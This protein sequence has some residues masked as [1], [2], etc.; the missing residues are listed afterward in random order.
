MRL[1]ILTQKV[2]INDDILGFFHR[3]IEEF[4]K[5]CELVIVICLQKGECD[6]PNNVKALSLGK[7]A[8]RSRL[9]Y[10]WRF[11][12]YI[13]E[14]RKNYNNVFVHMNQEYV[15]LGGLFWK[16]FGK[17]I[18]MWRN[19]PYGNFLTYMAVFLSNKVFCTSKYSYTAKFKKT[20]IMPVGI[21]TN[22]FKRDET[23]PRGNRS[24]LFLG[25]IAPVKNVAIFV[26]ALKKLR[27]EGVEFS[28]TIAG[29]A[30]D[31]RA[32]YEKMIRDKVLEYNLSDKVIFTGAVSK[33]EALKLYR[34][35]EFYVNLTPSGSMDKTI[36]E[37]LAC[38]TMVIVENQSLE[39]SIPNEFFFDGSVS[40]LANKIEYALSLPDEE[41]EKLGKLLKHKVMKKHSL[42]NL[43]NKLMATIV[44]GVSMGTKNTK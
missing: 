5:H 9:K 1:L 43:M 20:E 2:D 37:A 42:E 8:G 32:E 3:W 6:L 14:E 4:A 7:E 33:S 26:E 34:E 16:I 22:L 27:D 24:I 18:F 12:K 41:K 25:R 19:H 40:D 38:E 31:K 30:S 17:K 39:D 10:I 29:E 23:I 21:D 35:H 13:W 44:V 11:Y 28:A 15:L 36:F